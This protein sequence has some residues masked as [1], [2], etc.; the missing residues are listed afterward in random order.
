VAAPA[1]AVSKGHHKK[2]L[3]W[4]KLILLIGLLAVGLSLERLQ[5]L[6]HGSTKMTQTKKVYKP[7]KH[8]APPNHSAAAAATLNRGPA[9]GKMSQPYTKLG[10]H[11]FDKGKISGSLSKSG[12]AHNIDVLPAHHATHSKKLFVPKL[13][14]RTLESNK[15]VYAGDDAAKL[16]LHNGTQPHSLTDAAKTQA[17]TGDVSPV[18]QS[19][20]PLKRS[21]TDVAD[22][23]S[24]SSA[25]EQRFPTSG[26]TPPIRRSL[27]DIAEASAAGVEDHGT[28]AGTVVSSD[29]L[30]ITISAGTVSRV[31]SLERP[32]DVAIGTKVQI[33]YEHSKVE[34]INAFVGGAWRQLY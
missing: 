23:V 6:M 31:F 13:E 30:H 12:P 16:A 8:V 2:A 29:A 1:G 10:E 27:T 32:I 21:L 20:A 3:P 4:R 14:A 33:D 24:E 28:F 9:A 15:P 22:S 5:H 11:S 34:R 18:P 17:A 26:P 7:S 19:T 25:I